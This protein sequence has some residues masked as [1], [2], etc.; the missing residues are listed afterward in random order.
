LHATT[1]GRP[2]Q[3]G[4]LHR[5]KEP[6]CPSD[7]RLWP[8]P[9][10]NQAAQSQHRRQHHKHRDQKPGAKLVRTR[11]NS[12]ETAR[13]T[14]NR[15]KNE[16]EITSES[17]S[18]HI[19]SPRSDGNADARRRQCFEGWQFLATARTL[20]TNWCVLLSTLTGLGLVIGDRTPPGTADEQLYWVAGGHSGPGPPLHREGSW[21]PT[22][23]QH[24]L[25]LSS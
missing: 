10:N 20:R 11:R 25:S 13:R 5:Q 1:E 19:P 21:G 6:S 15:K 9:A 14:K 8:T 7:G 24:P 22:E 3:R 17:H 2:L 18:Y 12:E 23:A 4:A 16:T